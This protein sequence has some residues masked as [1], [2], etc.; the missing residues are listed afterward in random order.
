SAAAPVFGHS[1]EHGPAEPLG[2][3][4]FA[5]MHGLFWLTVNLCSE[6]ALLLVVDDL[7]WCDSS[8]LRFLAY[9]ARRLED[10]PVVLVTSLRSSEPE[11]DQAILEEIASEPHAQVLMP[12]PLTATAVAEVVRDRLGEGVE[13]AFAEVCHSS[14]DGNPLLLGELLKALVADRV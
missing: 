8:S 3:R 9:L 7:H 4:T 1:G 12:G 14:T 10:L 6:R 11:A 13:P 2:E 5:V